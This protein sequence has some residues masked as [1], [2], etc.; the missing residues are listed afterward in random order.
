MR[1]LATEIP[2][3][4]QEQGSFTKTLFKSNDTGKPENT[5]NHF[6]LCPLEWFY[7]LS[8]HVPCSVHLNLTFLEIFAIKI[9]KVW[10]P[11]IFERPFHLFDVWNKD[12]GERNWLLILFWKCNNNFDDRWLCNFQSNLIKMVTN[13]WSDYPPTSKRFNC[14][15]GKL[16]NLF[17]AGN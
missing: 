3:H 8:S 13:S 4:H 5:R 14:G 11:K 2:V 1:A 9:C 10:E 7:R 15:W 6:I 16:T 12:Q 17:P